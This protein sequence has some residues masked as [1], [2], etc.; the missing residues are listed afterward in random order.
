LLDDE[1]LNQKLKIRNKT[2]CSK[3][4]ILKYFKPNELNQIQENDKFFLG[5][6]SIL[7]FEN[8]NL[9]WI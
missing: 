3:V 4:K 2:K 8:L 6:V 1:I 5:V 7:E 9:L